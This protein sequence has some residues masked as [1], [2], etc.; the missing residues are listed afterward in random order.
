[1]ELKM[2][3]CVEKTWISGFCLHE[4]KS[5]FF[6]PGFDR[7]ENLVMDWGTLVIRNE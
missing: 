2:K 5:W 7:F 3:R 1:V 4:S 6:S